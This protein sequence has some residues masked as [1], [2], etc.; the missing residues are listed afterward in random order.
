MIIW[1][2]M[3]N[4]EDAFNGPV[5]VKYDGVIRDLSQV[6]GARGIKAV[7]L[8]WVWVL[9]LI[10]SFEFLR[11]IELSIFILAPAYFIFAALIASRQ[12]ALG[13]LL[14]EAVHRRL[15]KSFW[16]N[17]FVGEWLIA[18]P[19]QISLYGY[20]Q[21]HFAH[22]RDVGHDEDPDLKRMNRLEKY[23]FPKSV[24]EIYVIVLKY[25]FGYYAISDLKDAVDE[26]VLPIPR[27]LQIKRVTLYLILA[28]C[29]VWF[30]FWVEF[31]LYWSIPMVTFLFLYLYIRIV[32]EH[33]GLPNKGE[34]FNI[35]RHV[36]A[37]WVEKIF[38]GPRNVGYHLDHHLFPSVP[39]Y[40]LPKLHA[41]LLEAPVYREK[42]RIV[43]GYWKGV[44]MGE[45][46][47]K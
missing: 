40:N 27:H 3:G 20:R 37:T 4:S 32:A 15:C 14:H 29:A 38:L 23:R 1:T 22:H 2:Q 41:H 28:M 46:I 35:T 6:Q 24:L 9:C 30:N 19:L 7:G 36:N 45:C 26:L 21:Q 18:W 8:E 16:L 34:I 33:G 43:R 5:S 31:I 17:D 44:M 39:F 10:S 12:H 25:I 47:K 42:A 13:V 11:Q